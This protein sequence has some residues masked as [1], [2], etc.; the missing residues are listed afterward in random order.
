MRTSQGNGAT[1]SL[2]STMGGMLLPVEG[3]PHPLTPEKFPN[4]PVFF[5]SASLNIMCK[6][7]RFLVRDGFPKL[8][9]WDILDKVYY[10]MK[11]LNTIQSFRL[12]SNFE[13]GLC[14]YIFWEVYTPAQ[15]GPN[16]PLKILDKEPAQLPI[17]VDL[18][19][20]GAE[21][22]PLQVSMG[23]WTGIQAFQTSV[24]IFFLTQVWLWG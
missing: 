15:A 14:I 16:F 13:G 2:S 9:P 22:T 5:L 19:W 18:S 3:H 7:H 21:V 6:K 24:V 23:R 12:C 8:A 17:W 20:S 4:N 1:P 11:K 10:D